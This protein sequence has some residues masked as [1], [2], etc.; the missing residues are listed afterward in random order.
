MID[1]LHSAPCKRLVARDEDSLEEEV[2]LLELVPEEEMVLG[3]LE[4]VEFEFFHYDRAHH[5]KPGEHP[6]PAAALR[7]NRGG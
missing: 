3:E 1:V 5:V 4:V 6:A 7:A 2:R